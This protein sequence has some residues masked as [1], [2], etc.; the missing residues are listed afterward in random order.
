MRKITKG[1]D[2]CTNFNGD[3]TMTVYQVCKDF[4]SFAYLDKYCVETNT[5][6]LD[7]LQK[8]STSLDIQVPYNESCIY[9]VESACGWPIITLDKNNFDVAAALV[10]MTEQNENVIFPSP[11]FPFKSNE[12]ITSNTLKQD[13]SGNTSIR[14]EG[15][16]DDSHLT[17]KVRR[18]MIV[19]IS[20]FNKIPKTADSNSELAQEARMLQVD[21]VKTLPV[22]VTFAFT[23]GTGKGAI[24]LLM[25][26]FFTIAAFFMI[27][28]F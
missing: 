1:G 3:T 5:I 7:G 14:F 20:N 28:Q 21:P 13:A 27:M 25:R 11:S 16:V 12:T 10:D 6:E 26:S 22:R 4:Y 15:V 8:N 9:R 17:C 24:K 18:T 2:L 19:T 23:E